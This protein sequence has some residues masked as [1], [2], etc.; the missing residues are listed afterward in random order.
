ML[1]ATI[2]QRWLE[3]MFC[4]WSSSGALHHKMSEKWDATTVGK[5]GS[6]GEYTVQTGVHTPLM[7]DFEVDGVIC[8]ML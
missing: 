8:V 6:G 7:N 2:A 3:T 4:S 5:S 1:A